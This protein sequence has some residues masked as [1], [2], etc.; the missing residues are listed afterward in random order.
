[1]GP[2][3]LLPDRVTHLITHVQGKEEYQHPSGRVP[4]MMLCPPV[5]DVL[6][7][8]W[9]ID[10]DLFFVHSKKGL[11][12]GI[13][14]SDLPCGEGAGNPQEVQGFEGH[15]HEADVGRQVLGT[16]GV[17][18]MVGGSAAD[19]L[20]KAHGWRLIHPAGTRG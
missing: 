14:E 3:I 12:W 10:L 11:H 9:V 8:G 20:L 4:P 13:G 2:S 16:L 18:E 6:E 7:E 19:I 15:Q 1:M 17:H 5:M